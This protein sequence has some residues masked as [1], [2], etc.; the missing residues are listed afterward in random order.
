METIIYLVRHG[1]TAANHEN[2]FAGRTDEPLHAQ[3]VAQMNALG[4]RLKNSGIKK[5]IAGP[6]A[7]TSHSASL[8][9]NMIAAPVEVDDNFTDILIAHWDGL[10]KEDITRKFGPQYPDWCT[11]PEEFELPGCESLYQVQ[12]RAVASIEQLFT[13]GTGNKFLVVSH[14][15]VLRCLVLYY[16]KMAMRDFRS[17]R[18]DNGIICCLTRNEQGETT[19]GFDI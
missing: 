6:L 12:D 7:R 15:I 4:N 10:T 14:L 17:V 1:I 9:G 2:R 19:V 16:Q 13:G 18:I 5:V 8:L 3:G 11:H